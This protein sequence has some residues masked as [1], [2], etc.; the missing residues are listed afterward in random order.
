ME[1]ISISQPPAKELQCT[2][3]AESVKV[4]WDPSMP[5]FAKP[6]F[7]GAVGDEFGWLGGIDEGGCL[8]CVLPYTV[9]RKAGVQMVRFRSE[10]IPT[11]PALNVQEEKCFLNRVVE[12]FQQNRADVIIPASNNA[13]FRT[14]P[15]CA[16]AAPYG[17]YFIELEQSESALWAAVSASHRR[18]VRSAAKCG[19]QVRNT[20]E[21]VSVAHTIIRDTFTKSSM[22]FMSLEKFARLISALEG[23]VHLLVASW[24]GKVQCC[25]VNAFSQ[26]TAY[27]MYGGSVP[28]AVPGAMHLLHW[29][30]IRM[31]SRLGVNRYDFYG[32][33]INPEPGSKAAGLVTF[34]ERFGAKLHQGYIWKCHISTLKSAIYSFGVRWLRSGDIVDREHHKLDQHLSAVDSCC[35]EPQPDI[36]ATGDDGVEKQ[37]GSY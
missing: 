19:V 30:A 27:Y 6:E 17:T 2:L 35:V 10:T 18:H 7:L 16:V 14:Y 11:G 20:P 5:V 32:A 1:S 12:Y 28:D 23:N 13:I 8:R 4:Q 34:K 26:H 37:R 36:S 9:I 33:R 21:C 24:Q 31:Y 22:P 3:S 15:D 29:E 25:A